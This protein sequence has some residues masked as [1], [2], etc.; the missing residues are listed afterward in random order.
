VTSYFETGSRLVYKRVH[1]TDETGQNCS[2][3]NILRTTGNCRRLSPTHFTP[4][5]QTRQN[6]LVLSTSAV[7]T[8]HRAWSCTNEH[9][10]PITRALESWPIFPG[11]I[12]RCVKVNLL[13]QGFRK[14]LYY[15]LRMHAFSKAWSC[16]KDGGHTT[17]STIPKN[18]MLQ[19]NLIALS[20]VEPEF[21]ATKLFI[22]GI[23]ICGY[24]NLQ[25]FCS[26]YLNLDPMTFMYKL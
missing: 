17:G 23:G 18:P 2:V 19:A 22:V 1:T 4:Q 10:D 26:C 21:W 8:R 3:S 9:L 20:F 12:W 13:C 11:D 16:D 15:S 7:W 14:L 6:S 5:T 25:P 24:R